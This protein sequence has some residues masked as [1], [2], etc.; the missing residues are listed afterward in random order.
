MKRAMACVLTIMLLGTPAAALARRHLTTADLTLCDSVPAGDVYYDG[1]QGT[2]IHFFACLKVVKVPNSGGVLFSGGAMDITIAPGDTHTY[3]MRAG[4]NRQGDGFVD[5][6][7]VSASG[8]G[9][10]YVSAGSQGNVVCRANA[11]YSTEFDFLSDG[12]QSSE[13][14]NYWHDPNWQGGLC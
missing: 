9:H 13:L 12:G 14:P 10:H 1:G 8:A 6:E 4:I 7:T 2:V 5:G 3:T 11:H